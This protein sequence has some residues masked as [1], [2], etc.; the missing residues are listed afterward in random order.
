MINGKGLLVCK[1]K[2]LTIFCTGNILENIFEAVK[3][4]ELEGYSVKLLSMPIMKPINPNF[5]KSNL[6]ILDNFWFTL[7]PFVQNYNFMQPF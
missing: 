3:K 2:D 4:I 6:R 7:S 5:I 1:G